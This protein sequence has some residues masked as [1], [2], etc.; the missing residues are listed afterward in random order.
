MSTAPPGPPGPHWFG[1]GD[2]LTEHARTRPDDTAVVC[3][4]HRS[5]W[6]ELDRRVG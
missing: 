6:S 2:V 4:T 5:S 3:G 1:L